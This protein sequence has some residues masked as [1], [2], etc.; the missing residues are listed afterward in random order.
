MNGK[1]LLQRIGWVVLIVAL[2]EAGRRLFAVSPLSIP[3]PVEVA[4]SL[5]GGVANGR[6]ALQVL[7]SLAFIMVGVAVAAVLSAAMVLVGSRVAAARSFFQTLSAI[8]HP[9]PGIA[10]LPIVILWFGV[11][12]LA[13]MVIVVHSV[14]WPL[15][16]NFE[17]GFRH[18]PRTYRLVG[19]NLGL[20]TVGFFFRITVP[21][22][23]PFLLAGLRIAWARSWRAVISA[24]MIFGATTGVGGIG[25]YLHSQ[26]VFMDTAGLFA[27]LIVIIAVGLIVE[28]LLISGL[29]RRTVV[30]WGVSR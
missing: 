2:W 23:V 19:S 30:R 27:G 17:A 1:I 22:S 25:W 24:E 18:L 11:G 4:R 12:P 6:L 29:E 21:A 28:D 3:S 15:L 9:L 14:L 13:V 16:T 10:L 7:T 20:S 26:R 8:L 5:V